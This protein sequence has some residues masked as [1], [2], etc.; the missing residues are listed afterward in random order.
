[1]MAASTS[2]PAVGPAPIIHAIGGSLGAALSLLLFYP[3]ERARIE[4]QSEASAIPPTAIT[5]RNPTSATT[6]T[7]AY[8]D[9][10]RATTSDLLNSVQ[11]QISSFSKR[12]S[13]CTL[14]ATMSRTAV[15]DGNLPSPLDYELSSSWTPLEQ[16][17]EN[18]DAK[19]PDSPSSWSMNSSSVHDEDQQQLDEEDDAAAAVVNTITTSSCNQQPQKKRQSLFLSQLSQRSSLLKCLLDLQARGE[20]YKGVTPVISTIFTSQFV[21]FFIHAYVKRLLQS[22]RYFAA[23]AGVSSSLSSSSP[24]A[25]LSLLASCIA[26]VANVLLTNPLWVTNMAIV[27]GETKTQNL[28]RELINIW[29]V[30]GW[31]HLWD[32]TSASILLVSNP[33]I[34]FFCYEQFKHTRLASSSAAAVAAAAL[35]SGSSSGTT[36]GRGS[37][38][39]TTVTSLGALEAFVIAALAKGIATVTTYPLQL[40]QTLL[41]LSNSTTAETNTHGDNNSNHQHPLH[42]HY[43]GTVD[44]LI[45][46]YKS[47]K[48]F[49]AWFTG[50]RAKLLQTVLTAAF[51]FLT[52]EQILGAV[53]K[54]LTIKHL[55]PFSLQTTPATTIKT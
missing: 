48:G 52:Y 14:P 44:C 33:I 17:K 23:K 37:Q 2:A 22:T 8:N 10:D 41:R 12:E 11:A 42:Q 24:S 18:A 47:N 16:Q 3:L 30:Y 28:F 19:S 38:T 21:F 27:T 55:Q 13:E 34:Q 6:T 39:A 5:S 46:L 7:T 45:Q 43:E 36:S 49:A 4:L 50:M 1:M 35:R 26:G 40:T 20:L 54:A 25:V 31:K 9:Q 51:T 15:G 32:G 29:K 53:Q